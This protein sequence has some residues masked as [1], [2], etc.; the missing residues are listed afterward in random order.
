MKFLP[1]LVFL[2][3]SSLLLATSAQTYQKCNCACC[4]VQSRGEGSTN[5]GRDASDGNLYGCG[6]IYYSQNFIH[7]GFASCD[8]VLGKSGMYCERQRR[9]PV[10]A[11]SR[12]GQVDMARFCFYEC[13]PSAP[14]SEAV[15]GGEC[16]PA[17]EDA[18][19]AVGVLRNNNP[20][21][22][23]KTEELPNEKPVAN[24]LGN[25]VDLAA[26]AVKLLQR[27]KKGHNLLREPRRNAA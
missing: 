26:G 4:I 17:T 10:L 15:I 20:E 19:K 11:S 22:D 14:L 2:V 1:E 7:E 25:G 5:W 12:D 24:R 21:A 27:Q 13:M 8:T 16:I 3:F 23:G 18:L 6:P 9:D